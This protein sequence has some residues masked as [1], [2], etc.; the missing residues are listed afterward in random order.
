MI[1][2]LF[3]YSI[4]AYEK[5]DEQLFVV[6]GNP[7]ASTDTGNESDSKRIGLDSLEVAQVSFHYF[8]SCLSPVAFL[9]HCIPEER[10]HFGC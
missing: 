1:V 2:T 9:Q 4:P 3:R 6:D 5:T 7:I 10:N 8:H